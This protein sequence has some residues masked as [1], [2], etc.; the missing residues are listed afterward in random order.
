E[1]NEPNPKYWPLS[2]LNTY[3]EKNHKQVPC[4]V[5]GEMVYTM[6][7][8]FGVFTREDL[9]K[10]SRINIQH[11]EDKRTMGDKNINKGQ[12]VVVGRNAHVHDINFNQIWEQNK[13]DIDL[14]KLSDELATLREALIQDAKQ[15]EQF[16][17]LAAIW[18]AE[19]EA[20]KGNGAKALEAMSK[21]GTWGLG[22]AEKIGVSLVTTYIK[23]TMGL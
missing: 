17:E 20:K 4:G 23:T 1:R 5:C 16:I 10:Q 18:T 22:V 9:E 19:S 13:T 7:L 2:E 3:I 11:Y 15:P 8:I 6:E 21:I 12:A 14:E